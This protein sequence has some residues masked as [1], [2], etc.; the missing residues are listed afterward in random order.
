MANIM[1]RK[2]AEGQLIF[3]MPKKD[4][5]EVVVAL[6]HDRSD[7]WGGELT[8]GDGSKYY[9]EPMERPELPKTIRAKRLA[10]E[11]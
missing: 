9:V 6:E 1:L 8:L 10:E 4:L 3:Y 2:N 7:K 11:D 5:E